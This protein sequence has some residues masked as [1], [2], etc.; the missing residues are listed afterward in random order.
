MA[1]ACAGVGTF[2]QLY[3][4]Q[5]ILPDIAA[6]LRV[7]PDQSALLISAA[8]LGLA[9]GVLPWSWLADRV[10][11]LPAMNAALIAATLLGFAV[12]ICPSFAGMLALRVLEGAAIGGVP[13]LAVTYLQEEVAPAHSAIAAGTYISG[14]TVGGLLGR[15]VA[16][17]VAAWLG[18]REGLGAVILLA[19]LAT[20]GFM[21]LT[22]EPRGF[23]R[24]PGRRH[25]LG[26]LI[27]AN[28]SSPAQLVLYA[29][30]F[31]LMGGFVTIY[32]YLA[33]RLQA[34][35]FHLPIT[36]TSLIFLAYLAGTW[37][38]RRAGSAAGKYGRLAV[39][40]VSAGVMAA[41]VL[42]TLVPVLPVILVGLV[43]LTIGFFGAHAIAS[44]WTA[45]RATVGRAQATSLYNL[46]YYVGSSVVGWAGGVVFT[47]AGWDATALTVA[48]LA[49]AAGVYAASAARR[50]ATPQGAVA[51]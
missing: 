48:G 12:V 47:H 31:L 13:A 23:R 22:P 24:D 14:T 28:L 17:P 38:S 35:P 43:I 16:G 29:Q 18:W 4:P 10:G 27:W 11:R 45:A 30:A 32:N 25:S 49:V 26:R 20:V 51:R 46:F 9:A 36:I 34:A 41:G 42:L 44:G 33:F 3:S 39:L 50:P 15:I 19:A 21:L 6:S 2:A 1:L 7:T 5:G 37:S 8:T 40:L